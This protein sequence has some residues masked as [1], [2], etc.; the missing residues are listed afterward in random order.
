MCACLL[1]I[2]SKCCTLKPKKKKMKE[3]SNKCLSSSKCSAL[4]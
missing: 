2:G 4:P 3:R 1:S